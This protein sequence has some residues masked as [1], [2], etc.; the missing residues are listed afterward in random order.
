MTDKQ[1]KKIL[2]GSS[3]SAF[4]VGV[5]LTGIIGFYSLPSLMM[6]EDAS[7]HDFDTTIELFEQKVEDAGWSVVT[8][9]DMQ[10]ILK[11]H[12]HDVMPVKI[13]ELCSSQYSAKILKLD[14][15]RIVSPMMPCRIAFYEKSDGVTYVG[16]MNSNLMAI[17]FGG[18]INQVMQKAATDT[19]VILADLLK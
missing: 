13:Y 15:A 9:H 12:G 8:V 17:P 14:D 7:P 18:V 3:I 16:R 19:E 11:S 1:N 5:I 6:L 4:I 10:A 2:S